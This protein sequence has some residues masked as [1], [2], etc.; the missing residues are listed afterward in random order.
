MSVRLSVK[1]MYLQRLLALLLVLA[2]FTA[3][4]AEVPRSEFTRI[5]TGDDGAPESLQL[6]VVTYARAGGGPD[7]RVDL[8]S[9]VH[10]GDKTYYAE[11]NHLF[12][13]YDALLYELIAPPGTVIT[14]DMRPTG[15]VSGLQRGLTALLG[16]SFQLEEIDYMRPNFVHADLSPLEMSQRMA[17]RDES[18][19]VYFWRI[20]YASL[21]QYGRDPLNLRNMSVLAGAA[22]SERQTHPLKLLMAN[23]FSDI[24]RL[25]GMLGEDSD[26][27]VIG[28]RN[29]R[30]IAVLQREID[31]GARK[32]GIFYGLAHMRDLE[33][34]L[35]AI[36]YRPVATRWV[37]AWA[38]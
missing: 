29:E 20:V 35:L 37:D 8:I 6:A 22:S 11:L 21:R 12:E 2:P 33:N 24:D 17:E 15:I 14:P 19:Y 3:L 23:E 38:L 10:V 36:G 4:S 27:A 26:S 1:P 34:R 30:A 9:A 31:A 7:V 32:L 5:A 13:T 16:L 28:A 18:L 25:Q